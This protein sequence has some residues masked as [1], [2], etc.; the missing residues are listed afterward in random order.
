MYFHKIKRNTSFLCLLTY[1]SFLP[2]TWDPFGILSLYP[3]ELVEQ[4]LWQKIILVFFY[5][6]A[7]LLFLWG[8]EG[9][10]LQGCDWCTVKDIHLKYSDSFSEQELFSSH[11]LSQLW[12]VAAGTLQSQLAAWCVPYMRATYTSARNLDSLHA[13]LYAPHYCI[14]PSFSLSMV[15]YSVL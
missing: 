8:E 5:L 1:H 7:S 14:S 11:T 12:W 2:E 13:D 4:V 6:K 3:G 15:T 10:T 9:L